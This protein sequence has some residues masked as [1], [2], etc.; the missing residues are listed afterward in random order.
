MRQQGSNHCLMGVCSEG[1][2]CDCLTFE[3]CKISRC[4]KYTTIE[5]AIPSSEILFECHL[6]PNAG[7]CMEFDRFVETVSASDVANM[8][9]FKVVK[10]VTADYISVLDHMKDISLDKMVIDEWIAKLDEHYANVTE[11]EREDVEKHVNEVL[12]IGREANN[13]SVELH[14]AMA[15]V[16]RA[17]LLGS[18]ARRNAHKREREAKDFEAELASKDENN[19]QN[20]KCDTCDELKDKI[21][22]LREA[23]R[24]AAKKAGRMTRQCRNVRQQG[25]I[26]REKV[27]TWKANVE[28]TRQHFVNKA[29]LILDRL[30][31]ER[32]NQ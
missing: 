31:H 6:T 10:D 12:A 13:L 5:N 3:I 15:Q 14:R 11:A 20:G 21:Q 26:Y 8:E 30:R 1:S 28:K 7:T 17:N 25:M 29:K 23:V 32:A 2:K 4:A 22:L 27:N 24:E 19:I 16:T 18:E 9:S